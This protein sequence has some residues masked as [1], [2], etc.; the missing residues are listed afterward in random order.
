MNPTYCLCCTAAPDEV[1]E[2]VPALGYLHGMLGCEEEEKDSGWTLRC[3]FSSKTEALAVR[4]EVLRI[5]GGISTSVVAVEHKDWLANWRESMKPAQLTENVVVSPEWLPPAEKTGGVWIVIEPKMAFGTGHHETTR[6]VAHAMERHAERI[7]SSS[8][9]D[10]GTG[11]GILCFHAGHL[12]AKHCIG[13][14]I[15]A[16]CLENLGENR[17]ANRKFGRAAFCIA[18]LEA[19][20]SDFRVD[21][22]VMN[23]LMN[24]SNPL[25][26]ECRKSL[27]V[28]GTLIWSGLLSGERLQ[29]CE[30]AAEFGLEITDESTLEEWWCGV[31]EK[32]G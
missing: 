21:V 22:I 30:N 8:L 5:D 10:I 26:P 32:I 15:D 4:D 13:I 27:P 23:M 28:G 11:S 18:T 14:E 12:G 31:F 19:L 25:L 17:D 20:R 3:H 1:R 6:L 16:D 2:I 9:L 24:K 29:A 7:E